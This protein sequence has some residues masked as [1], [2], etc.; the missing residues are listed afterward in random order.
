[1]SGGLGRGHSAGRVPPDAALEG[2]L[3]GSE[4][5]RGAG[6]ASPW[7]AALGLGPVSGGPSPGRGDCALQVV[8][9]LRGVAFRV[10]SA[11]SGEQGC[12]HT[13]TKS[14]SPRDGPWGGRQQHPCA[15]YGAPTELPQ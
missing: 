5:V 9:S 8:F 6:E 4:L 10:A 3:G 7:L 1:M 14:A 2:R 12:P 11:D 15:G 13:A